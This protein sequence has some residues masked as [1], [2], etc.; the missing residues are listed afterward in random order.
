MKDLKIDY[1]K[2]DGTRNHVEYVTIMNFL[3]E[4]EEDANKPVMD[5]TDVEADFFENP[6]HHQHFDSIQALYKH[7]Q[8]I[9]C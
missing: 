1:T 8:R 2:K 7:C 4:M 3:D 9:V 6:L 5:C